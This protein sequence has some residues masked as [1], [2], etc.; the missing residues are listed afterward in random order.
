MSPWF[1]APQPNS[2]SYLV[3][4]ALD[5][6]SLSVKIFVSPVALSVRH[7]TELQYRFMVRWD[8]AEIDPRS[9]YHG[10]SR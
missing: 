9:Q 5:L 3:S 8:E 6:S 1:S 10:A 2:L 7:D 4:F